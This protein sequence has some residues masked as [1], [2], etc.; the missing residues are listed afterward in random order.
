MYY[1]FPATAEW[2]LVSQGLKLAAYGL[3]RTCFSYKLLHRSASG[4]AFHLCPVS[5]GN[6]KVESSYLLLETSV[7]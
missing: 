3:L 6:F 5:E 4:K 7:I 1:L 2:L